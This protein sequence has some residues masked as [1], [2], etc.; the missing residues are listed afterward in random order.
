MNETLNRNRNKNRKPPPDEFYLAND[1]IITDNKII[2]D[3]FN[4][5]F[6]SI[7]GSVENNQPN[8]I[9]D[10]SHTCYAEVQQWG[11]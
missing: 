7:G 8:I 3:E 10:A 1:S 11:R 5:Y 9:N 2:T 6:V 4:K